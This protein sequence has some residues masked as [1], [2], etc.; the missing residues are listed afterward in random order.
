MGRLQD[1]PGPVQAHIKRVMK[2][3]STYEKGCLTLAL[4][5]G[6]REEM[7]R[8]A[9]RLVNRAQRGT[10]LARDWVNTP[11]NDKTPRQ[12]ANTV[13]RLTGK[14]GL[15]A[16]L[17][18]KKELV[19]QKFGSILAV[20]AGSRSEPVLLVLE[21]APAKAK[22]TIALVGKGVTFDSGGLN[23]KTTARINQMKADMAGAAAVAAAMLCLSN[24]SGRCENSP[25]SADTLL[26]NLALP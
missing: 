8:A 19:R 2:A 5:Y 26:A 20:A 6:A 3:T 9:R 14:T 12:F 4:S 18:G 7:T 10:L 25:S 1:L 23:L 15:K 16:K 17:L 22:K 11:A 21:H 13:T 24:A